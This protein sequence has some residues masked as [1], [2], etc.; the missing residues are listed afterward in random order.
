MM[1][2]L[3]VLETSTGTE[4]SM[5]TFCLLCRTAT[6]P[7][8]ICLGCGGVFCYDNPDLPSPCFLRAHSSKPAKCHLGPSSLLSTSL[9]HLLPLF[10]FSFTSH[11]LG[12]HL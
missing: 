8:L 9:T 2:I 10:S 6:S 5:A 4:P 11:R 3:K 7:R 1:T 12:P